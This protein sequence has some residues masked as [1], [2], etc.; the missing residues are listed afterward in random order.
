MPN[1]STS[2]A[3]SSGCPP[4]RAPPWF[5]IL[6]FG[7]STARGAPALGSAEIYNPGTGKFT[8]TGSAADGRLLHTA[9]LLQ[10]GRVLVAGG[11]ATNDTVNVTAEIY[12]PTSGTFSLTG[13]MNVRRQMHTATLLPDGRVLVAGGIPG[14]S[15]LTGQPVSIDAVAS[16]DL[17]DPR[18]GKFT[19][20]GMMGATRMGHTATLLDDGRVLIAGGAHRG[21]V[22]YGTGEGAASVISGW[23][24]VY[25]AEIYQP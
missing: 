16:A 11:A 14:P 8:P 23:L 13:P 15:G 12:D 21:P 9:T 19:P 25:T 7:G 4:T 2:S 10:D 5:S 17:Y 18:T 6:V 22:A 3:H 1:G 24:P 20:A